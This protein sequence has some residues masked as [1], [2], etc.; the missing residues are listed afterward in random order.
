MINTIDIQQVIAIAKQAGKAILKIYNQPFEVERKADDSPLTIADKTANDIIIKGLTELYPDIP[1]ISEETKLTGYASRKKWQYC[2]LIDPLDGTKEFVKKNGEFT[3]NIALIQ[4]G[5]PVIGIIYVPVQ[6]TSYY[7]I[8][9]RG[10]FKID[11]YQQ[12]TRNTV[13]NIDEKSTVKLFAS[14]SHR[15]QETTDFIN[16]LQEKYP[17]VEVTGAGSSLKFCYIAEG[18]AHFYPRFAPTME[19]DTGA[20]HIIAT[21]AGASVTVQPSGKALRYNRENLLNPYFLVSAV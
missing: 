13:A 7:A 4:N 5:E 19:W 21:E 18:L 15:N 9:G 1:Y 8:K 12:T 10:S 2:W 17:K 14:R 16:A 6:A 20:G 3:V 11:E